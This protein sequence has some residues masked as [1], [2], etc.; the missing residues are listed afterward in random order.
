MF[1]VHLQLKNINTVW[2]ENLVVVLIWWF[3][4]FDRQIKNHQI[5]VFPVDA[6]SVL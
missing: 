5:K 2:R 6:T 4:E 3:G 1:T